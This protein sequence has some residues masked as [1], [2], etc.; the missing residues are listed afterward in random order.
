[1][2]DDNKIEPVFITANQLEAGD[3]QSAHFVVGE[4]VE[5]LDDKVSELEKRYIQDWFEENLNA[6]EFS[7]KL[8]D[9]VDG[10][11]EHLI[12]L[13]DAERVADIIELITQMINSLF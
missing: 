7:Q 9:V 10:L 6:S 4:L 8:S 12:G 2:N 1:M 11:R 3:T 13:M 5:K